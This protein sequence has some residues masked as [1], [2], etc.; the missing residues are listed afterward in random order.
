MNNHLKLNDRDK[1]CKNMKNK[2]NNKYI[3]NNCKLKK[4]I[5]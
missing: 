2:Q 1:Y 4:L 3:F 5:I